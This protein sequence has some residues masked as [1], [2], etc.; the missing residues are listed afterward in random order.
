MDKTHNR[1]PLRP[2]MKMAELLD[3]DFSLL[4]VFNR[5]GLPF[6]FGEATVAEVCAKAGVDAETFLLICRVYAFDGYRP[7]REL[8]NQAKVQD[9]LD[10]L[11][12][13]HAYYMDV[14]LPGLASALEK[15]S[16]PC[17]PRQQQVIR[18]FFADYKEE[19][20]K[21]FAYEENTVFP[22]VYAV[23]E[24]SGEGGFSIG[25]YEENHSNVEEKLE[26]LKNLVMKYIPASTDQQYAFQALIL[27]FTLEYDLGKHTVIED[28]I[29]VP[30]VGRMEGHE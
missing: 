12:G 16:L 21:H 30:M 2:A 4:G 11:R 9:I 19:L 3:L 8:L 15:M 5:M 24:H 29:L 26:D 25:E 7:T 23:L 14:A 27:I 10:Y 13:S 28:E 18:R 22:Y 17:N 20:A 1:T 6:G